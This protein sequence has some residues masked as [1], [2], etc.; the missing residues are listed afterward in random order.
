LK[1]AAFYARYS[2]EESTSKSID[3][4]LAVIRKYAASIGAEE[5]DVY[6]DDAISGASILIRPGILKLLE[7]ARRKKFEVIIVFKLD[8]LS[9]DMQ[10]LAALFKQFSFLGVELHDTTIGVADI[11]HVGVH[12]LLGTMFIKA[13]AEHVH[14]GQL[15]TIGQGRSAGGKAYGYRPTAIAGQHE[16][17]P[18]EAQT[19]RRI[20]SMRLSGHTPREIAGRLNEEGVPAPRGSRWNAST[21][22]GSRARGNGILRNPLYAGR[23]VWDRLEMIRNP[24]TGKRIS[25]KKET[26]PQVVAVPHL[27]IIDDVTFDAVQALFEKSETTK[28]H[29]HRKA[30]Y[31][32]S[33]RMRCECGSGLS[34]KD[35]DHGRRRVQCS[36]HKE[37]GACANSRTYYLDEIEAGVLNGVKSQLLAPAFLAELIAGYNEESIRQSETNPDQLGAMSEQLAKL[38]RDIG[39]VWRDYEDEIV[40][41]EIAGPR[42]KQMQVEKTR[43]AA[44]IEAL[45]ASSVRKVTLDKMNVQRAR[46]SVE[47]FEKLFEYGVT[48]ETQEVAEVLQALIDTVAVIDKE[49]VVELRVEGSLAALLEGNSTRLP[50]LGVLSGG[51][52][53]AEEGFEPPTQGL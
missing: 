17:V 27:A 41:R 2:H 44:E 13:H 30:K 48:D 52:V 28:P 34:I 40:P 23:L 35:R 3:D 11:V 43:L 26:A 15:G 9:R 36:R 33:G 12:A 46:Q 14:R 6:R 4:Q 39:R 18:Q 25:R 16:I 42:L 51:L 49:A 8:R 45:Q 7:D 24:S 47:S 32:L 21:I 20:F 10:D 53:V 1:R 29:E 38:E 31:L 22:N 5:V 19:I 37:S 50:Q